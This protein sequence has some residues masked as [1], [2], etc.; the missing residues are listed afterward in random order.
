[1]YY[2]P[3]EQLAKFPPPNYEHPQTRGNG[4]V[5]VNS[6]FLG[7]ATVFITLRVYK[8]LFVRTWYGWD[9]VFIL[10]GYFLMLALNILTYIG[11]HS[12]GFNRHIWD[13]PLTMASG[14]IRLSFVAK[15][16]IILESFC[17]A[18]SLL[19]FYYRLVGGVGS[20]WFRM[21]LHATV[22]FNIV[23]NLLFLL[24]EIFLCKPIQ[25]YW[26][27]TGPVGAYCKP[28]GPIAV[29]FSVFKCLLDFVITT[30]PMPLV[31]RTQMRRRQRLIVAGLFGLGYV[32]SG[33]GMAR[34]YYMYKIFLGDA[35]MSWWQYPVFVTCQIEACLAIV[36]AC[37]P[38]IRPLFPRW[39][40]GSISRLKY[41]VPS[42]DRSAKHTPNVSNHATEPKRSFKISP[43]GTQIRV[44][45]LTRSTK[46][47]ETD[48]LE[49]VIQRHAEHHEEAA[50]HSDNGSGFQIGFSEQ[51]S[52][53]NIDVRAQALD[54]AHMD[55]SE[56]D[57]TQTCLHSNLSVEERSHRQT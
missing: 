41:W 40:E 43:A 6:V 9:D 13:I 16:I 4:V 46:S 10:V 51:I 20:H 3:P 28:E 39:L 57:Q 33:A 11:V 50:P 23:T 2:P 7:I 30:L 27:L 54:P 19:I 47:H 26:E 24:F 21:A 49:L 31:L 45:G 35:D 29:T 1:M 37:A 18:M 14:S 22:A 36:C 15:I 55:T 8:R 5:I 38:I 42:R 48:D 53:E 56:R 52:K 17:I 32:V 12:Y 44:F 34:I 25:F